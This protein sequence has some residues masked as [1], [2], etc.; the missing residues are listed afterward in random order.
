M[1]QAM[2]LTPIPIALLIHVRRLLVLQCSRH[3][4]I[5]HRISCDTT[6]IEG[7]Q[8]TAPRLQPLAMLQGAWCGCL[9]HY[10]DS[11]DREG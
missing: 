2:L 9:D 8:D 5:F 10:A 7:Y 1:E 11:D 6:E 3:A 4:Y